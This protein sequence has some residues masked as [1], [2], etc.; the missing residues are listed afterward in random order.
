MLTLVLRFNYYQ[1]KIISVSDVITTDD[2]NSK[3]DIH[4]RGL[5]NELYLDDLKKK[6]IRGL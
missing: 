5:I 2:D 1:V 6:T 3:L 4:F